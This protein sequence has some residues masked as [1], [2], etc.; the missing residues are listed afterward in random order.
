SSDGAASA[1]G[2]AENA[3]RGSGELIRECHQLGW[4]RLVTVVGPLELVREHT[5]AAPAGAACCTTPPTRASRP[6][7]PPFHDPPRRISSVLWSP[8]ID[9]ASA[10]SYESPV[11]P[12]EGSIPAW[13]SRS[14]YRIDRYCA[15]RSL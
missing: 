7:P 11:L 8:M 9:S 6:R 15:T 5:R 1:R 4:S 12:T 10:L 13:A 2:S 14:V 3:P